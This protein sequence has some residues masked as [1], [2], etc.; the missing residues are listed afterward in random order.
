ML[1]NSID[2][3]RIQELK[4]NNPSKRL[5]HPEDLANIAYFL[6][7]DEA[8]YINGETLNITGGII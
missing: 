6:T 5:A 4:E 7:T 8:S 2:S 3:E 1:Y